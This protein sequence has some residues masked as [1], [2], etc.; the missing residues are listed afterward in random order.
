MTNFIVI[1]ALGLVVG[2]LVGHQEALE[3]LRNIIKKVNK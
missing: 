3:Q 1:F 2:L